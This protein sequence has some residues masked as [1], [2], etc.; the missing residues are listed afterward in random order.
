M[1]SLDPLGAALE[2]NVPA[3]ERHARG[4]YFTPDSVVR[5]VLG[6][7][8][9]EAGP[10]TRV[11]DPACGSGRFLLGVAERWGRDRVELVGFETD[12]TAREQ[13]VAQLPTAE[14]LGRSFLEE[15]PG[16][17]F[18]LVVGNPPY[19][20]RR[21]L[22]RDVYVD[23]IEAAL[24]QLADG[25]RLAFVL[26]NAWLS[27]GYGREVR[28]VLLQHFAIEW[29]VESSAESWFPGASVNTMVLVARRCDDPALR[30][31]Q[32]V[33]FAQLFQPL[34]AAPE[35]VRS[36][37][38]DQLSVD[39]AWAP[40]LRAPDLYLQ[41]AASDKTCPLGE[42]AELKRGFTTN[43]NAFFY[44]PADALIE[45]AYL[46]PLIKGP[47]DVRSLRCESSA[48]RHQVLLC[49]D[50][51]AEL[52]AAGSS[53]LLRWL[54]K[55]GKG[56]DRRAWH[57]RPQRPARL[58]LAKGYHDRFRQPLS[59]KPVHADQQIYL[60]HPRGNLG[61]EL[62]AA[63]LNNS[64][65]QLGLELTG[66]VNFGDGVLWLGLKD[67]RNHLPVPDVRL[68]GT[69][70]RGRLRESLSEFPAGPVPSL[71][72]FEDHEEWNSARDS[73]DREVARGL[74]ITWREYRELRSTGLELCSRRL[75]LARK[76]RLSRDRPEN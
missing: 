49:Q 29:I 23:F 54:R 25:A 64:W 51:W 22:K 63:L 19:I 9:A 40:L 66:R 72:E 33:R 27:V 7:T 74:D 69:A 5:F 38:Q 48:L 67:A 71:R 20:R 42:L 47:R 75:T 1:S 44:P 57:L 41:L 36:V 73:L 15:S 28:E 16:A 50:E 76:R 52:R 14:V 55:H 65:F 53:G 26:S 32:Q 70:S 60:V 61:D 43:D 8:A 4:Q 12:P 58:F 18:D 3:S 39:V 35:L 34:P 21:G 6:L 62:L 2:R 68:W 11:L 24:G 10:P 13:A 17:P 59:D 30:S 31:A 46:A 56:R 37:R 45:D